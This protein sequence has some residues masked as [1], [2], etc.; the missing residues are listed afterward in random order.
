MRKYLAFLK[1]R[2][3]SELRQLQGKFDEAEPLLRE[4]LE[5]D[6]ATMGPEHPDYAL[7][8]NNLAQVL[9]EKV[10]HLLRA[11]VIQTLMLLYAR[12]K[13]KKRFQCSKKR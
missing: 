2:T 10:L 11:S 3:T 6:K 13:L 9:T 7:T 12:V 5:L 1:T 4:S 8:L